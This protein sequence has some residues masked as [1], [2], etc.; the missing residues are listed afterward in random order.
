MLEVFEYLGT[1]ITKDGKLDL[2]IEKRK[3]SAY[4]KET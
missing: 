3:Q 1:I 2:E 4:A